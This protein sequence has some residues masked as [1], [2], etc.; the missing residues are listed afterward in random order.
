MHRHGLDLHHEQ[1][2]HALEQ[3]GIDVQEVA[4]QD[5]VCLSFQELPPCWRRPPRRGAEPGGGQDPADRPLP[6]PVPQADQ[7]TLDASVPPTGV[8]P[9]HLLH[10][11]AHLGR[12]RRPA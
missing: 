8:L 6:H 3:D 10:Q 9:R 2:V 4:G 12:Y 1:H 7:L 5:A 11:R